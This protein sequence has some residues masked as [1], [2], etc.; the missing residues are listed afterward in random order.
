[1][2]GVWVFAIKLFQ[3]CCRFECFHNKILGKYSTKMI[4]H[5]DRLIELKNVCLPFAFT[6]TLG[7]A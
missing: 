6:L 3:L 5:I 7:D 1:M 2:V 4:N